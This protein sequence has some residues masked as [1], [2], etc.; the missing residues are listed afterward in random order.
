MPQVTFTYE[1]PEK[2]IGAVVIDAFIAEHYAFSNQVTDIP[3][4]EGSI[5]SDHVV[6]EQDVIS[7]EAFIGNT[8]FETVI[9][10]GDA[11]AKLS[12]PEK[13]ARIRKNY[14]DLLRLKRAKEPVTVVMGLETFTNMMITSFVIDRDAESGA[15]LPFSMEFK[16]IKIVK[17]ETAAITA[18]SATPVTGA[19]DQVAGTANQGTA[20]TEQPEESQAK[21]E[22]RW[23]VDKEGANK[24][25]L[26]AYQARWGV[27][28]P[29]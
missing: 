8:A 29:Q 26:A 13:G 5:I 23:R 27:P 2:R 4:E 24:K 14:L 20:G 9:R 11:L 25:V 1:T 19:S 6:E 16:K 10:E 7:V 3:V 28:Y 12:S 21:E 15:D 22:W 18:S 17:S